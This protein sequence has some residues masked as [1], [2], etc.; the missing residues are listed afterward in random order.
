MDRALAFLAVFALIGGCLGGETATTTTTLHA[1][2]Q[3]TTLTTHTTVTTIP[4]TTVTTLGSIGSKCETYRNCAAGLLCIAGNCTSPPLYASNFIRVELQKI[5]SSASAGGRNITYSASRFKKTEGM[6]V[7]LTPKPET[8]GSVYSDINNAVTGEK[9][10][11]SPKRRLEASQ[12]G[13]LGW[14]L[15]NPG[16]AG[17]YE[18]NVFY[19]DTLTYTTSFEIV[20]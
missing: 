1:K 17:K 3:A 14:G 11:I 19:N 20:E 12:V 18:L 6:Y 8:V 4:S 7:E 13:P 10:M 5:N 15:Q 16:K 2:P 9:I